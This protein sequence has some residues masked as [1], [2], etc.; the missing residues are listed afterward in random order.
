[1]TGHDCCMKTELS[2]VTAGVA[3]LKVARGPKFPFRNGIGPQSETQTL[4]IMRE[5]LWLQKSVTAAWIRRPRSHSSWH[6][7]HSQGPATM[8]VA[9]DA[10]V[11]VP[12]ADAW[13][14]WSHS[15]GLFLHGPG[16]CVLFVWWILT[17]LKKEINFTYSSK[18]SL[19]KLLMNTVK[20]N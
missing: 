5:R 4:P 15:R 16:I 10:W 13:E 17:M 12:M 8:F 9:T 2:P 19:E 6:Q 14:H 1:M 11:P 7:G 18:R 3:G 20:T